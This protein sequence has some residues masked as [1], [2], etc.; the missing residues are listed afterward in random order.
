[1]KTLKKVPLRLL[2]ESMKEQRRILAA[3][4]RLAPNVEDS[5]DRERFWE[6]RAKVL[7]ILLRDTDL[8]VGRRY[9]W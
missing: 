1:M 5:K 3:F 8:K 2:V 6:L 7:E 9:F 4:D